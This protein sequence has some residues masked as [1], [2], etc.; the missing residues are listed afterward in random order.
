MA[1]EA[2]SGLK[3]LPTLA[4]FGVGVGLCLLTAGAY[5]FVFYAEV[6]AS[7]KGAETRESTLRNDLAAAR[8]EQFDYQEDLK[9]LKRLEQRQKDLSYILPATAETPQFL[10]A[11]QLAA[12]EAGVTLSAWTPMPEVAE[13]FYRRV[14][15]KLELRGRYHQLAQFFHSVGQIDRVINMENITIKDPKFL[16]ADVLAKAE[17][18]ATAFRASLPEAPKAERVG[19]RGVSKKQAAKEAAAAKA[20]E[21]K[22]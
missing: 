17:V 21:K 4:K 1:G 2:G 22:K 11:M 10:S 20:E 3:S 16:G 6:S 18:T 14:P 9:E 19:R 12:N 13:K 7:I 8:K 15:M 5:F